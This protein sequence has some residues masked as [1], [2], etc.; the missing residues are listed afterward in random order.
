MMI[1]LDVS[2]TFRFMPP[3][4]ILLPLLLLWPIFKLLPVSRR[5][6]NI[7]V[8][9]LGVFVLLGFLG[10]F[11]LFGFLGLVG[12]LVGLFCCFCLVFWFCFGLF[13]CFCF[14]PGFAF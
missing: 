6:G 3:D 13:V 4:N 1:H 12:W 7:K 10:F 8:C 2:D 14:S 9:L 11:C 5:L